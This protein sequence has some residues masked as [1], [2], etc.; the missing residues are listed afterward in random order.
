M[1]E[2]NDKLIEKLEKLAMIK[3]SPEEKNIIKKDLND[4]LKY[5]QMIDE[6]DTKNVKPLF[7]P[8]ENML[9][10]VFHIDEEKTSE[11]IDN[12]IN[13]FPNQKNNLLKVPGIQG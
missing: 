8:I 3:L 12:I 10:N 9:K 7:S 13:E 4:I 6:I 11:V 1:I 5:M 2:V